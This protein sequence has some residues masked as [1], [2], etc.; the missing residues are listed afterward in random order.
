MEKQVKKIIISLIAIWI[1]IFTYLILYYNIEEVKNSVDGVKFFMANWASASE[2]IGW[3]FFM[4]FFVCFLG[5]ASIGIPIPFVLVLFGFGDSVYNGY[6]MELG[7]MELVFQNPE[8]W[9][10]MMGCVIFG[11]F[12]CALGESTSWFVG[13]GVKGVADKLEERKEER[14]KTT[15]KKEKTGVLKNMDGLGKILNK[16]PKSIP[17][18]IFLFALTPL[19]DD[20]LFVPLGIMKHP[21]WRCVLPG[22]LGKNFTTFLYM[23]YPVFLGAAAESLGGDVLVESI[24]LG[25][26]V[27][28]ILGLMMYDWN[29]LL[30]K[31]EAGEQKKLLKK[32]K[33][34]EKQKK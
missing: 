14:N 21:L 31:I 23:F 24:I 30:V 34:E 1:G 17:L 25:I 2:N 4:S 5:S 28:I 18:I 12:G 10:V 13:R 26:S 15:E 6:L 29:K 27:T 19:P 22:W 32:I 20:I 33:E 7:S 11:G 3:M 16:N 9:F 8:F